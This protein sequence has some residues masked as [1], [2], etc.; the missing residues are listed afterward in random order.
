[1]HGVVRLSC[2]TSC[3]VGPGGADMR[4]I[5][6]LAFLNLRVC[7]GHEVTLNHLGLGIEANNAVYS[8]I[9]LFCGISHFFC[10]ELHV[11]KRSILVV[12]VLQTVWP[13]SS[14]CLAAGASI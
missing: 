3:T 2:Y 14:T 13:G 11:F 6:V 8:L 12:C 7:E 9:V 1:M 5:L 10:S 4:L